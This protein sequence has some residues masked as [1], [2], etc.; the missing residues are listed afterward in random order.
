M[1][2]QR[3]DA[4]CKEDVEECVGLWIKEVVERKMERQSFV[5][6]AKFMMARCRDHCICDICYHPPSA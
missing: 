6:L 1:V 4:K 3:V 2:E 5:S